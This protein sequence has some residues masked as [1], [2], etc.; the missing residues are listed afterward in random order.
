MQLLD[1]GFQIIQLLQDSLRVG[2]II[3]KLRLSGDLL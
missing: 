2:L 1:V 3:P